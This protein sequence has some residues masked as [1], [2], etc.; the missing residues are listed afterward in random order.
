MESSLLQKLHFFVIR[1]FSLQIFVIRLGSINQHLNSFILLKLQNYKNFDV[2]SIERLKEKYQSRLADDLITIVIKC[3]ERLC[4]QLIHPEVYTLE[5][6]KSEIAT[7]DRSNDF[8]Y[9]RDLFTTNIRVFANISLN[10]Y[11]R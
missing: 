10:G 4:L 9:C 11:E 3:S 2:I 7:A 1:Y 8:K 6:C 5:I